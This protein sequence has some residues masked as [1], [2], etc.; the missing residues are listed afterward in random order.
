MK[1]SKPMTIKPPSGGALLSSLSGENVGVRNYTI[2]RNWRRLLDREIRSEGFASFCPRMFDGEIPMPASADDITLSVMLR[3]PNGRTAIIVGTATT[4]WKYS[5]IDDPLYVD[6][7]YVITDYYEDTAVAW[8]EIGSG[9]SASGRRWEAVH[10]N[11]YLVLNNAVDLP[12]TYRM[13]DSEVYPIYELRELA[14]A[15]VGAIAMFNSVLF[16]S[17]IRQIKETPFTELMA[18]VPGS[19]DGYVEGIESSGLVEATVNSGVATVAGNRVTAESDDFDSGSGFTFMMNRKIRFINSGIQRNIVG[20]PVSSTEVDIDGDPLLIEPGVRF[21][22]TRPYSNPDYYRDFCIQP[23]IET[24]WPDLYAEHSADLNVFIGQ[25]IWWES[26]E[27]ALVKAIFYNQLGE[28]FFELASDRAI[29]AGP[30]SIEPL[31]AYARFDDASAID[32]IQWRNIRSLPE[33]PRRFGATYPGTIIPSSDILTLDYPVKSVGLN[34]GDITITGMVSGNLSTHAAYFDGLHL[35]AS[36]GSVTRFYSSLYNAAAEATTGEQLARVVVDQTGATLA[37]ARSSL[38]KAQ[39]ESDADPEDAVLGAAVATASAAVDSA[40]QAKTDADAALVV[41]IQASDDADAKLAAS[42][43]VEI[44]LSDAV[45]TISRQDDLEDD[46]S[47]ILRALPLRTSLVIYKETSIFLCRQSGSS[48]VFSPPIKIPVSS[49]LFYRNTLIDVGGNYH[50]Y[51]S[52]NQFC[53][54][55]MTNQVPIAVPLIKTCQDVFFD[56]VSSEVMERVF[57]ADNQITS[58]IYF[59]FPSDE[60]DRALVFEY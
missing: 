18:A 6:D 29:P 42:E 17:D 53:R 32:R 19:V 36:A 52:E 28:A 5:G 9:F 49:A 38:E 2:K 10:V 25:R 56:A 1:G 16:C 13:T 41:A 4:L 20:L 3:H 23:K 46:G 48:F 51:A 59:A 7:H 30:C 37:S 8:T 45:S 39:V 34:G 22:I 31:D 24:L 27:S 35:F 43:E 12:V 47:A 58:E 54:F 26:G 14:V 55:D 15:S 40:Q 50:L 57:A 44:Q 60:A 33:Q 21:Y 11:G